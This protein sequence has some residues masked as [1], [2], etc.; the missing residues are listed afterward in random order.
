MAEKPS[1]DQSPH[2]QALEAIAQA[3]GKIEWAIEKPADR[4][5]KSMG[6]D[7]ESWRREQRAGR[8]ARIER[9][10]SLSSSP[11][12]APWPRSRA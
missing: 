10:G 2:V 3:L 8:E 5:M 11:A 4:A 7:E 1:K 6:L 12:R 9:T